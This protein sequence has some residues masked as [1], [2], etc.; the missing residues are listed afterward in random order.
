MHIM[1]I[2]G[3][4][5][6]FVKLAPIAR[7]FEKLPQLKHSVIHTGQHYDPQMSA[8]FFDELEL[9]HPNR[10][11]GVGSASHAVQTGT[12]MQ[13]LESCFIELSPDVVLVYGDTNSTLAA[14]LAASKLHIPTAHIEAGLRSFNRQMPEEINRI[15]ADHTCDRLY[16]PSPAGVE[17][18]NNENLQSRTVFSGDVMRDV[19]N[20]N[21]KLASRKSS[22]L[23]DLAVTAGEFNLLTLHR[24]VNTEPEALLPLLQT[25]DSLAEEHLPIV[26]PVHPRTRAVLHGCKAEFSPALRLVEPLVYL[27]MLKAVEASLIVLTDS[28]GL[29]KEAAFLRTQCITLREET[30]WLE[31]ID[32]GVNC[33]VGQDPAKLTKAFSNAL[34]S[35]VNFDNAVMRQLDRS[36]GDGHAAQAI[37]RDVVNHF[38]T[39]RAA[40]VACSQ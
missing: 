2:V 14:C 20:H 21:R 12:L 22:V 1:S 3:A 4:R 13:A 27:D 33:L 37:V 32:I 29:Q 38:S 18:L 9:P 19:V 25:L 17:N 10:D 16:A 15:V 7:E 31:T 6:Q 30:E 35:P 26:F 28:G 24:P 40:P 39:S 36:F 11:L 34:A 23:S 5:P 8:V